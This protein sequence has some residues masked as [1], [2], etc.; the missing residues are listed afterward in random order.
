MNVPARRRGRPAASQFVL[1]ALVL[2]VLAFLV[3][4]FWPSASYLLLP[5]P[6]H[7]VRPLVKLPA[8]RVEPDRN[9]GG[10]YF[11]DVRQRRASILEDWFPSIR[12]GSTL[13][14]KEAVV[15]PGASESQVR[16]ADRADMVRSQQVAAAVAL[17]EAGFEVTSRPTGLIVQQISGT[18]PARGKL[19]LTDTIVA[20]DG[21][22]VL[23][24]AALRTVMSTKQPGA[25]V[26]LTVTE[27]KKRRV[28]TVGTYAD[29]DDPKHALIGI[30]VEQAAKI[31]LPFPVTIDAGDIGG[32]SAGLAFTLEVLEQLGRDVDRG[33]RVAVTG[34]ISFDGSVGP[35][36][37]VKQKVIGARKAHADV[38]IVPA[39]E[40]A[41][42]ARQYA[43]GLRLIPVHTLKEALRALAK[44]PPK[45]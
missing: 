38:L 29:P 30:L 8:S 26:R 44:L 22:P 24:T 9:G 15:P 17:R 41:G 40:N 19:R 31:V 43:K 1:S 36:G 4:W 27:G 25:P 39:V 6:A 10:I 37:G 11:L 20:I 12:E 42:E 32:P 23:T 33:Y 45:S 2:A 18:S 16:R 5:D 21:R 3:L 13:L 28:V 7:P 34:E 14:P 35:I